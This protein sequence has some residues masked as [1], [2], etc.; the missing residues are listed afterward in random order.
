MFFDT[1][2]PDEYHRPVPVAYL[3]SLPRPLKLAMLVGADTVA[4]A[5]SLA[6]AVLLRY[7]PSFAKGF[8]DHSLLT[9]LSA[10]VLTV[11]L[12]WTLG[13]YRN[14]LRFAGQAMTLRIAL[15]MALATVV[16]A[17]FGFLFDREGT[18]SR[19]VFAIFGLIGFLSTSTMRIV[20]RRMLRPEPTSNRSNAVIYGAG[21]AG[22]GLANALRHDRMWKAIAF[23]DDNPRLKGM[24]VADLPVLRSA[25]LA[26]YIKRNKV[27]AV[28][29]AIPSANSVVRRTVLERVRPTG[30]KVLTVPSLHDLIGGIADFTDLRDIDLEDLLGR[31]KVTADDVLLKESIGEGCVLVTGGGG[32]IGS[33][34]SRQI[35]TASPKRL[36][37][38]DQ[39][40]FNL[41]SVCRDLLKLQ[42][43]TPELANVEI[44]SILGDV[45]NRELM[46]EVIVKFD[47]KTI[48]HAAA[49]KHV[50]IVEA[51]I[52]EGARTNVLGTFEVARAADRYGVER[53]VLISTDKAVRPTSVMGATKRLAELV[54]QSFAAPADGQTTC[55]Y[56]AV[57]FGNVLASS[58]SV[59]PLFRNQIAAG[60]PVTVTDPDIT[61]FFMT[62]P[63]AA[64]L[65]LQS[66]AM[67]TSGDLFVLDMGKPIKILDLAK[68]MIQLAGAS[69]RDAANPK[70]D[71]EITFTGL[72]PGEKMHEELF[73]DGDAAP[74]AHPRIHRAQETP[75]PTDT[76]LEWMDALNK[77]VESRDRAN[78]QRVLDSVSRLHHE[79]PPQ[80]LTT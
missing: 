67:S 19:G 41:Y 63:E 10:P 76:V 31:T 15:V 69:I 62:I 39:S 29:L 79:T 26:T 59:V 24:R 40:E 6:L 42:E 20:I 1:T 44:E 12:F 43:S 25:D 38:L 49:Y 8:E 75:L 46:R 65:V 72:R 13:V 37:V 61:R 70:G 22:A 54:I 32:S 33:E 45:C 47:V 18:Q 48:F 64:E 34:L 27:D 28:F 56:S 2:P 30:V 21:V 68:T 77:S 17:G 73:V 66:S 23:V 74:T 78:I 5:M 58:G 53:C 71:I 7:E 55:Q 60:G 14:I 36:V 57:R 11:L 50:P 51:N 52:V 9:L 35:L 80:P 4:L 3:S 16:I